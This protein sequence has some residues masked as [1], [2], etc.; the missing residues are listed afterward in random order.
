M[1][2]HSKKSF[3]LS[4]LCF[5][6]ALVL[7]IQGPEGGWTKVQLVES[8]AAGLTGLCLLLISL[9][10]KAAR[11]F[12]IADRDELLKLESLKSYRTAYRG[13]LGIL[14]LAGLLFSRSSSTFG[15][16]MSVTSFLTFVVMIA[17]HRVVRIF[18][19]IQSP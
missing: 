16:C 2:I 10:R 9:N 3:Y 8:A 11:M 13:T 14:A 7:L 18:Q 1:K 4:L 15:L 12:L 19:V 6:I 5:G 17:V